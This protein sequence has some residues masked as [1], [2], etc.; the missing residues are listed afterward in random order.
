MINKLNELEQSLPDLLENETDWQSLFIDYETPHVHRLWRQIDDEHR[1]LL[2]RIEPCNRPYMHK[3]PWPSAVHVLEGL[4]EM[5]VGVE[6]SD[7]VISPRNLVAAK[8][9]LAPGNWYEMTNPLAWHY[10]KPLD[11]PSY[12][13]M[14]IAKPWPN[15]VPETPPPT[16]RA[17]FPHE[18]AELVAK[19]KSFFRKK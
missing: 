7:Q 11:V 9:V 14:L 16:P 1:L 4:Y 17:L 15:K 6:E 19:F 12:S 8:I 2:H 5:E 3:H 18:K 13:T 10:V